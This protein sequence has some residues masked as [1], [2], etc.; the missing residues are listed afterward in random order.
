MQRS[1]I[2]FFA[3]VIAFPIALTANAAKYAEEEVSNGGAVQ[4]TIT[5]SGSIKMRTVLPT[6]DKEICGK[7][8][9]VPTVVVGAGGTVQDAVVFIKDIDKGKPWPEMA[10]PVID[11]EGCIFDPHVQVA[12]RGK[13]DII[14]SDPVLHNTHGYY[15]KATA[16][17]VAL[18]FKDAKVTKVL[19]RTGPVKTDCDAHG[20]MLGWLYVVANPYFMQTGA[21]GNYTIGDLP[22]GDYTLVVWQES[23]GEKEF[24]VS[25]SAG[26]T[27]ELS[28]ELSK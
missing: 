27:T 15:G 24:P 28:I 6:K 9:K 10:R 2:A 13:V 19:K 5:Y 3:L 11:Q 17:N 7:P 22:A 25:I 8:R 18:P 23:V 26:E 16:F 14:N 12:R 21:D 1:L 20:W 4:G